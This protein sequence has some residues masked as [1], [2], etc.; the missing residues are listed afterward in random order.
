MDINNVYSGKRKPTATTKKKRIKTVTTHTETK[1][2]N[3][4]YQTKQTQEQLMAYNSNKMY[5]PKKQ[6]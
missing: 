6:F 2:H 5:E 4:V 3:Y 1:Q